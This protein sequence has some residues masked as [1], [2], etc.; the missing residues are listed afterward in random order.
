[1]V[2]IRV[3]QWEELEPS[4]VVAAPEGLQV[5]FAGHLLVPKE[6]EVRIRPEL[7]LDVVDDQVANLVERLLVDDVHR[8]GEL[9]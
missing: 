5:R 6:L 8:S 3:P 9:P 1:M 7:T 2:T 4:V